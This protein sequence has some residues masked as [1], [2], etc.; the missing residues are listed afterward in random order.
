M[1]A[2]CA[3]WLNTKKRER[4][5]TLL[6]EAAMASVIGLG[7]FLMYM[8]KEFSGYL[9][10]LLSLGLGFAGVEAV[11]AAFSKQAVEQAAKLA[12][13]PLDKDKKEGEKE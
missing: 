3:K 12:G 8:W 7:V 5:Q 10:C 2:A 6:A 9:G 13:L 1:L 11:A 4:R